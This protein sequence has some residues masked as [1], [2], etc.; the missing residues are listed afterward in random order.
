MTNEITPG[1]PL[2]VYDARGNW[3][4]HSTDEFV[5]RALN[6]F[7][8]W[9]CG[10]G[11][12]NLAIKP[13]GR[14]KAASC[15]VGGSLGNIFGDIKFSEKWMVCSFKSC[16]CGADLFI[17]KART[18]SD[19]K[20]LD[21]SL[22]R[23]GNLESK[24]EDAQPVV[25][26]ERTSEAARKQ[27]FWEITHRCNYD[28]SYCQ[29]IVHNKTDKFRPYEDI[30]RA[31]ERVCEDFGRGEPMNFI[32]SGG[33]PTLQPQFLDWVRLLSLLGHHVSVHSNGSQQ[34]AYYK[35]L[36]RLCDINLSLHFEFWR[37][38]RF[39]KVVETMTRT[40]VERQN[41]GVGHLEVKIMMPPGA[42]AQAKEVQERF[43]SF[44]GFATHCTV[45]IVPIRVGSV[46][47][48]VHPNYTSEETRFFGQ[49]QL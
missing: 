41:Q 28:C 22:G 1:R 26:V 42:L 31:T 11:V 38:E 35:Q 39:L 36:I 2:R 21:R 32:I 16:S 17:P 49:H 48:Q 7:E 40:K 13:D 27:V 20:I 47:E 30:L 4:D 43:H 46:L 6:G 3:T 5:G 25:A 9:L 23:S 14:V 29:P 8:G 34:P 12:R 15:G 10:A 45:S 37:S 18:K 24:V 44:E 33:E 19:V